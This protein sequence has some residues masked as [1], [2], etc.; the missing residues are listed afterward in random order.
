MADTGLE[1]GIFGFGLFGQL[2]TKAMLPYATTTV[3]DPY[4]DSAFI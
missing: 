3:H 2:L 1:V 4:A